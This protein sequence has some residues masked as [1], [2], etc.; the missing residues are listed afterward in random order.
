MLTRTYTLIPFIFKQYEDNNIIPSG[1]QAR[2]ICEWP[3]LTLGSTVTVLQS[4]PIQG[5]LIKLTTNSNE[6]WVPAH[7]LSCYNRKAW[8]FRFRKTGGRRT[9]ESNSCPE[10]LSSSTEIACPE[11]Q[12]KIRDVTAVCGARVAFKCCVKKC[13][14]NVKISWRK[15]EPDPCVVRYD[16]FHV[17]TE[18]TTK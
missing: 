12:E 17:N 7:V 13:G 9:V 5:H 4:D 2:V 18:R 11:F 16:Y 6:L 3:D 10:N 1:T 15:T 14:G 8:S